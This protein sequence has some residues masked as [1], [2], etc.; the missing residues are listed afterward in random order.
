MRIY[1]SLFLTIFTLSPLS[2][3]YLKNQHVK[4]IRQKTNET[5]FDR[6]NLI[7]VEKGEHKYAT[8]LPQAPTQ[9]QQTITVGEINPANAS[10][11]ES[12]TNLT[13]DQVVSYFKDLNTY[14]SNQNTESAPIDLHIESIRKIK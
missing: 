2:A 11:N 5:V 3:S 13:A 9:I 14:R 8:Q 10:F 4:D 12:S 7:P 6:K 1:I